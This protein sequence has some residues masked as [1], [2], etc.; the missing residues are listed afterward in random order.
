MCFVPLLY[1]AIRQPCPSFK[2]SAPKNLGN[3]RLSSSATVQSGKRAL[4]SAT[5]AYNS[6]ADK[7][8]ARHP[9]SKLSL[10]S[11]KAIVVRCPRSRDALLARKEFVL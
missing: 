7:L 5:L 6:G 1:L 9:R 10:D 11:E 2:P 8:D 4:R 3:W